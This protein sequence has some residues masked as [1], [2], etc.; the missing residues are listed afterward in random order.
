VESD[1]SFYIKV[2]ADHPIRFELLSAKGAVIYA[3]KSWIWA[4]TGED[5]PCIGCH[6]SK[7]LAPGDNWPLAL[8]RPDAP[9]PVGVAANALS[10]RH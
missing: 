6:E 8:K 3:Q 1:G 10:A 4:R 2:P 5:V 7:A 9:I